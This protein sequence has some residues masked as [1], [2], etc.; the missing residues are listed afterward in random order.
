MRPFLSTASPSWH[1]RYQVPHVELSRLVIPAEA[2]DL[3]P[4]ELA[5]EHEIIPI[6]VYDDTLVVAMSDPFDNVAIDEVTFCTGCQV[7]VVHGDAHEIEE[8]IAHYYA[9]F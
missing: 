4:V 9:L 5:Q 6:N 2:I 1:G 8:A 7:E 3:I